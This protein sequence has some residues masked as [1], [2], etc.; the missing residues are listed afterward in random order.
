MDL[1]SFAFLTVLFTTFIIIIFYSYKKSEL[2]YRLKRGDLQGAYLAAKDI[3]EEME[4]SII[5]AINDRKDFLL[6]KKHL[7]IKEEKELIRAI[8]LTN[9]LEAI[10]KA[11]TF[12]LINKLNI[13]EKKELLILSI[14]SGNKINNTFLNFLTRDCKDKKIF[15]LAAK[16]TNSP[17]YKKKFKC[18]R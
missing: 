15:A 11:I 7:N 8:V 16:V 17:A 10:D 14:K 12:T 4:K 1:L 3:D 2:R 9:S 13:K 5:Q 18:Q 6:Q